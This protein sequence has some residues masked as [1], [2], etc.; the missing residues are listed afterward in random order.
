M[1]TLQSQKPYYAPKLVVSVD[2]ALTD[3]IKDKLTQSHNIRYN[4]SHDS[5]NT[6]DIVV[7]KQPMKAVLIRIQ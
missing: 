7:G 6:V 1:A 5:W 4:I 3:L 2:T